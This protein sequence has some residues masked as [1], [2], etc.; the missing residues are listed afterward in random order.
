VALVVEKIIDSDA[1]EVVLNV[2]RFSKIAESLANFHLIKRE[3]K[4][5]EKKIIVESVDDKVIELAELAG[6]ESLNPILS[7]SRKQFSDIISSRR[8]KE[9]AEETQIKKRRLV[10][11]VRRRSDRAASRPLSA[12]RAAVRLRGLSSAAMISRR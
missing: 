11:A 5:L 7:K 1:K 2:P 9:E 3:A 12:L 6:I 10:E 4:L 8:T